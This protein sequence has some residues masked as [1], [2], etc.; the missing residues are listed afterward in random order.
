MKS[1]ILSKHHNAVGIIILSI[2]DI[3]IKV[4]VKLSLYFFNWAPCHKGILGS[5]GIAPHILLTLALDG[6]EWSASYPGHFTPRERAPG[7]HWIGGWV[8]PR[9]VLDALVKRKIPSPHQDSNP[10]TPILQPIAWSLYRLSY[11]SWH[12]HMSGKY[13]ISF[14]RVSVLLRLKLKCTAVFTVQCLKKY[15]VYICYIFALIFVSLYKL[16]NTFQRTCTNANL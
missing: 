15:K 11:H 2:I 10:R 1:C 7:N 4:K 12:Y 9:A 13:V 14:W 3:T 5:G 6:G 8:G 16:H